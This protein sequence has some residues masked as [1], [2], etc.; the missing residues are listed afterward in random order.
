MKFTDKE[1]FDFEMANNLRPDNENFYAVHKKVAD[2]VM[3]FYPSNH[4]DLGGGNSPLTKILQDYGVDAEIVEKNP[5]SIDLQKNIGTKPGSIWNED[6]TTMEFYPFDFVTSIEVFEHI[7][8]E[9]LQPFIEYLPY[10]AKMFLFSSTPHPNTPEFDE[11]WGHCN[12]KQ[13]D[14][15]VKIFEAAGFELMKEQTNHLQK[16]C[17]PTTWTLLFK[18]LKYA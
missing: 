15:W 14:E 8:D 11:Q 3:L 18:S 5:Y 13:T 9:I 10:F 4:L 2:F 12:L 7:P 6:F 17:I 16:N 1:F